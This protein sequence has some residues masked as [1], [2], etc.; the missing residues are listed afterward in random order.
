MQIV[1]VDDLKPGDIVA[2]TLRAEDGRVLLGSGVELTESYIRTLRKKGYSRIYIADAGF[3]GPPEVEEDLDP[4]I[5]A[6]AIHTLN[7]S[8]TAI[9]KEVQRVRAE[10]FD[11]VKQACRSDA[12][13][14]LTG[15]DGPPSLESR[16]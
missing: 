2:R 16:G 9:E 5:R 4:A 11:D 7:R 12:M 13:R 10:S 1:D 14:G 6:H 15:P 3:P 8:F